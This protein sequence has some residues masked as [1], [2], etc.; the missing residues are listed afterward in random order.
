VQEQLDWVTAN[1]RLAGS[2]A[3]SASNAAVSTDFIW[4]PSTSLYYSQQRRMYYNPTSAVYYNTVNGAYSRWDNERQVFIAVP[5]PSLPSSAPAAAAPVDAAKVAA[6]E[7][8]KQM[9]A[10]ESAVEAALKATPA[11]TKE[12]AATPLTGGA[13]RFS[14]GKKMSKD[15]QRWKQKHKQLDAEV[16]HEQ[17]VA[18]QI[19]EK[20]PRGISAA[21]RAALLASV[22][23][24]TKAAFGAEGSQD[25]VAKQTAGQQQPPKQPKQQA[26]EQP[27]HGVRTRIY[28]SEEKMTCLLCQRQFKTVEK[29]RKHELHSELHKTNMRLDDYEQVRR[30]EQS[31]KLV[32]VNLAPKTR[33]RSKSK[34]RLVARESTLPRHELLFHDLFLII[35]LFIDLRLFCCSRKDTGASQACSSDVRIGRNDF[36]SAGRA[37]QG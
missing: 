2:S 32:D 23:S 13:V 16:K 1:S 24:D 33:P 9:K 27:A 3:N 19:R 14:I 21:N 35:F 12:K 31:A 30:I 22:E 8:E 20:A 4:D 29:L 15:M 25:S 36:S 18:Q 28:V 11:V 5:D 10:A 34:K 37:C 7:A 26:S 6:A 17:A